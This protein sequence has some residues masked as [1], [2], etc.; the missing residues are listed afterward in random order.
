MFS[1]ETIISDL[2]DENIEKVAR[3]YVNI[4]NGPP[5]YENWNVSTSEKVIRDALQK[6]SFIGKCCVIKSNNVEDLVAFSWGYMIPDKD[7]PTVKFSEVSKL[8]RKLNYSPEEIFYGAE[9][10]VLPQFQNLG[11][12]TKTMYNRLLRAKELGFRYVAFR[13]INE[14]VIDIYQ[15]LFGTENINTL[16]NDPEKGKSDRLWYS[17]NMKNL[18]NELIIKQ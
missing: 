16:F 1:E 13:T 10:G 11:I 7:S 3:L 4:F 18:K 15:T 2:R 5:W 6:F 12:G 17:C 14:Q 9:S 8:L